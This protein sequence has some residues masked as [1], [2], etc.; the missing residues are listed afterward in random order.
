MRKFCVLL[1]VLL[2]A[3][4]ALAAVKII[5]VNEGTKAAINYQTTAGE[6]VRAF[7]LDIVV[8]TG[9]ITAVSDFI[10]G[11]SNA[12][13]KG[14]G[15]FPANFGRYITVGTD[16][17]VAD[18][19]IAAY[20]PVAD[21]NDVGAK[22]GLLTNGVTIEMGALYYP[23]NDT[24][25][26][27]PPTS[28]TLCKLTVGT[29]PCKMSATLNAVRGGVVLTDPAVSPTVDLTG[30]TLV[31]IGPTDCFPSTNSTFNDWVTMGKPDCWCWKYQCDGDTD[32]ATETALKYRIYTNDLTI[33]VNNWKKKLTDTGWNV[34][35][36]VDHKG[37]TALKYRVYN[38]DLGKVVGNWKKKDAQLAGDCPRAE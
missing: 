27:A 10:K 24:S 8:D 14:Y 33:V 28:G 7:A 20:T 9:T 32:N 1:A 13:Q 17:E 26:N 21:K 15:I 35:A 4:P 18:W 38:G 31:V 36:D 2:L 5:I 25:P 37:E 29:V 34:C 3:T 6:H 12:A 16:G 19:S 30:A 23:T 11:E 22:T